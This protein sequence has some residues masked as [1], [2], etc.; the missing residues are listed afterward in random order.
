[1]S[2]STATVQLLF[3]WVLIA[4]VGPRS[5]DGQTLRLDSR[6][7]V[8]TGEALREPML[9]EHPTGVLFVAG[10]SRAAREFRDPPNLYRSD[11][12]GS[13]WHKVDVGT[14]EEGALANSD[15]DLKVA[16]D[17]TIYF[18]TMGFDRSVGEGTHVTL[19][20][21]RDVGRTWTWQYLSENRFD[22]RPWIV[23]STSDRLH[24]IWND[25]A[26]VR[27]T[28]SDDAGVSWHERSRLHDRGGSSHLAAGPEGRLAV[29]ITP[30]S[31]SGGQFHAGT[32]HIAVSTDDG[33][34]WS[35]Q[36]AP[37]E[38]G[39]AQDLS[40]PTDVPRWVEP[41][42][43]SPDGS[44]YSLWSE[45]PMLVLARSDDAGATW[46]RRV[47]VEA[48]APMYYPLL[49]VAPDGALLATWF[50]GVE[51]ELRAH[52]GEVRWGQ[53]GPSLSLSGP[54]SVDAWRETEGHRAR[55]PAGE[56]FPAIALRDG[57]IGAVLP[58]Q[59]SEEGDGFSWIR[60]SR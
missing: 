1:M 27:H 51:D 37:G 8:I 50:A 55:E 7:E 54:L 39:W 11:D 6:T 33:D 57:G 22:D 23:R 34:S 16:S 17:G 5:L 10:Y 48:D 3:A 30:A 4:V 21:S 13:T 59:G 47:L 49:E 53:R 32:D 46:D 44:L 31:A 56:Y 19:G 35:L 24:V 38:R 26:G 42:A 45:G 12:Q 40:T 9:I 29:R 2:R 52:V 60:L 14:V 41:L 43:W 25:G 28:V 15:V 20:M 58:V 36:E 18:L